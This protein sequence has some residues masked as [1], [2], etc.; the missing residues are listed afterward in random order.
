MFVAASLDKLGIPAEKRAQ[1]QKIRR[2]L[3][4]STAPVL[5]AERSLVSKLADGVSA[6][7]VDVPAVDAALARFKSVAEASR[8]P[9]RG[10]HERAPFELDGRRARRAH[11]RDARPLAHVAKCKRREPAGCGRRSQ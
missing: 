2:D 1:I 6:G 8:G 4:A 10:G 9:K 3:D 5:A 7:E 11:Q